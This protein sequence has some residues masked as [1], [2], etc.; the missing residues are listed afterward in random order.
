MKTA[1]ELTM[2][3]E[4]L[5]KGQCKSLQKDVAHCLT[6][7]YAPFP[8]ILYC[9]STIDL[10]GALAGGRADRDRPTTQQ[11]SMYM[12]K[13]MNY[14]DPIPALL[15]GLFRHKLVH[16]ASPN[17]VFQYIDGACAKHQVTGNYTHNTPEKH[18]TL[19]NVFGEMNID[20]GLWRVWYDQSFWLDIPSFTK[21][22]LESALDPKGY[23]KRF[24]AFR[25]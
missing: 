16:L 8:A 1:D 21:E 19:D 5:L 15:L 18:L 22:I 2:H 4:A 25:R 11:T 17:P 9:F 23:L 13:F 24:G 7:P 20:G 14:S 6:K 3:A 10:F 12:K